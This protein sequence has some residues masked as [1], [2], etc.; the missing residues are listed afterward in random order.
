MISRDQRCVYV[1]NFQHEVALVIG[2]LGEEGIEAVA[3]ND[4][5]LGGL[6]GVVGIVPRAGI[7][8]IEVWVPDVSRVDEAR[9]ILNRRMQEVNVA[10]NARQSRTGT[11]IVS[12]TECGAKSLFPAALRGTVQNCPECQQFID[13]PDPDDQTEWPGDFGDAEDESPSEGS[14]NA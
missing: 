3:V 2:L 4:A 10:K 11:D 12:C 9:A 14:A 1:A 7:K 6:E 13:I 8:G 5:T